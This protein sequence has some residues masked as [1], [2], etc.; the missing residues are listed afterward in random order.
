MTLDQNDLRKITAEGIV[1]RET[2]IDTIKYPG[3]GL[4][5]SSLPKTGPTSRMLRK[6]NGT[7]GFDGNFVR[8]TDINL[9]TRFLDGLNFQPYV[10]EYYDCEDRAFWGTAHIRNKFIGYPVGVISGKCSAGETSGEDHAMIILWQSIG[11]QYKPIYYSPL[12]LG[13]RHEG[14][15]PES[16]Y[17]PSKYPFSEVKSI[18]SFPPG[19]ASI[20]PVDE[21]E[22]LD[23]VL[24]YD[25]NRMIYRSDTVFNYLDNSLY[26]TGKTY[27]CGED[28]R[29]HNPADSGIYWK[30]YD[31]CLWAF[32]HARRDFP[33]IP[34]GLAMGSHVD[35]ISDSVLIL[36]HNSTNQ[37][38]GDLV[39]KYWDPA[40]KPG[41]V[42]NF[43]PKMIFV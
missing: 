4:P 24:I 18:V 35:G 14:V 21:L 34:L 38:N 33:G 16:M 20:S 3:E 22:L 17:S 43:R 31:R 15:I 26:K 29:P 6:G 9:V 5:A 32:A 11:N 23:G 30:N 37:E 42:S 19:P 40:R 8:G 25:E 41:L 1:P 10:N 28:H 7:T 39:F 13:N 12:P 2:P 27:A 36:W